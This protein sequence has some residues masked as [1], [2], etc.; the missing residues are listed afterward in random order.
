MASVTDPVTPASAAPFTSSYN[1]I[2]A[3]NLNR[4]QR[5]IIAIVAL[6]DFSKT[7]NTGDAKD[8]STAA[9]QKVLIQ[10]AGAFTNALSNFDFEQAFTVLAYNM[11]KT[12]NAAYSN[13]IPTALNTGKLFEGLNEDTLL[14][15][16]ALLLYRSF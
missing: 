2:G 11:A 4:Q 1:V 13:D 3:P 5:L 9:A 7:G 15:M 8:Y 12:V 10:D 6:I 14:G 16:I